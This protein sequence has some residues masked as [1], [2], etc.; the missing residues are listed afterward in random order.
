MSE[1]IKVNGLNLT[2]EVQAAQTAV[3]DA[4]AA[5]TAAETARAGAEAAETG[6]VAAKTGAET[7]R[8]EAVAIVIA[9]ADEA[10]ATAI[11]SPGSQTASALSASIAPRV[12]DQLELVPTWI[13]GD[14]WS[15]GGGSTRDGTLFCDRV[16]ARNRMLL[17]S[18]IMQSGKRADEI[19]A[20]IESTWTP[21][22]TGL[23]LIA[24]VMLNDVNQF[25]ADDTNGR[26]TTKEALRSILANLSAWSVQGTGSASLFYGPGWTSGTSDGT[27][28]RYV[29][30]AWTGP[31]AFIRIGCVTGSGATVTI[32]DTSTGATVAT[33]STGNFRTAFNGVVRLSGYSAGSHTVRVSVSAAATVAGVIVPMPA[34][35]LIVWNKPGDVKDAP[36]QARLDGYRADCSAVADGFAN[37]VQ[38][39]V[40]E[41]WDP[42]TMLLPDLLHL[43]DLGNLYTANRVQ[44]ELVARLG[45]GFEQGVNAVTRLDAGTYIPPTPAYTTG[46]ATAPSQVTGL[47][48]T[49]GQGQAILTW[50]RATDGGATLTGY[51]VQYRV[52][53]SGTWLDAPDAAASATGATIT[54][55]SANTY[56][57]RVAAK[58]P[59]GTGTYSSTASAV[60]A[61]PP[62]VHAADD[63][64]RS[65]GPVGS[66]SVGSLAWAA[67]GG[68]WAI[69]SNKLSMTTVSGS[70]QVLLVNTGQTDGTVQATMSVFQ[71]TGVCIAFN[72]AGTQGYLVYSDSSGRVTL[73]KQTASGAY[74]TL[75]QSATGVAQAGDA[76]AIVKNG[77]S[78]AVKR[79]GTQILTAT[80]SAYSGTYSGVFNISAVHAQA[81]DDWSHS[82]ATS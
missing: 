17:V 57:F 12:L 51:S 27:A 7:A 81:W 26:R 40:D 63:F 30:V 22:V 70:Q 47:G 79:N 21:N 18:K 41:D 8:D 73:V 75:A 10:M 35:P 3:T 78:L 60:V 20:S 55:L 44:T 67:Q 28:G 37:V 68:S 65:D 71:N 36:Y 82:N 9:D 50:T 1:V 58:N 2:R 34:P 76:I 31:E 11:E 53:G 16:V 5:Q 49:G 64:N 61:A 54:G 72:S 52:S 39:D 14:S 69:A 15:G 23:V 4:E 32:T 62:T 33:F 56:E 13:K 25:S 46:S 43:N 19:L 66:T 6:A 74:T 24:D 48:A 29:D 80:D 42:A 45:D 38:V 77:S 59:V